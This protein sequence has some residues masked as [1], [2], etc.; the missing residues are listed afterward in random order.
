MVE[1]SYYE[2]SIDEQLDSF[3]CGNVSLQSSERFSVRQGDL[4]GFCEETDTVRY[5][6]KSGSLLLRWDAS[7]CSELSSSG[8]ITEREEG[9]LLLSALIG[10][11]DLTSHFPT[12]FY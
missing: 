7:G 8:R 6:E 5:Y 1:D 3:T 11:V 12:I 10:K 4:V 2:L 9:T